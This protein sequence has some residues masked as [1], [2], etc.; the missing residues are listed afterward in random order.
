MQPILRRVRGA[1]DSQRTQ[2]V[3]PMG[4]REGRKSTASRRRGVSM[5]ESDH[6]GYAWS[7]CSSAARTTSSV[8]RR[9]RGPIGKCS[10]SARAIVARRAPGLECRTVMVASFLIERGAAGLRDLSTHGQCCSLGGKTRQSAEQLFVGCQAPVK[11]VLV[12][13]VVICRAV[14]VGR[15]R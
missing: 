7:C 12:T 9:R 15:D 4:T 13:E 8:S 3:L 2:R 11:Q 6:E 10:T 5:G 14:G 1:Y